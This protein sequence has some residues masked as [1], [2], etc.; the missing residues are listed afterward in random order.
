MK[1]LIVLAGIIFTFS[2][3]FPQDFGFAYRQD[4]F[5]DAGLDT[6]TA[7]FFAGFSGISENSEFAI[8]PFFF[9]TL[10]KENF[11][12]QLYVR[13]TSDSSLMRHYSGIPREIARFGLNSAEFDRAVVGFQNGWISTEFGRTREIWGYSHEKNLI[14]SG[15]SP[16]YERFV[17]QADFA[18][19]S[20]RYFFGFLESRQDVT[21]DYVQ[22]YL[23]GR[24]LEYHNANLIFGL[25][26]VSILY[27]PNRPIDFA[28]L[29]PLGFH[30]EIEQNNR[31]NATHGNR[32]NAIWFLDLDWFAMENLRFAGSVLMD[33]F[34]LDFADREQNRGDALGFLLHSAWTPKKSG[35]LVTFLAD[36]VRIGTYVFQHE[37]ENCNFVSHG[38]LLGHPLGNDAE[39][40]SG[41]LRFI[42]PQKIIVEANLGFRQ[43]GANSLLNQNPYTKYEEFVVTDFPSGT[44]EI[45][46][47]LRFKIDAKPMKYLHFG[48]ESELDLVELENSIFRTELDVIFR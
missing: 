6:A 44:V 46:K 11:Y 31:S 40:F 32:E 25:G 29:N 20:Y 16:A 33:E 10:K 36:W 5:D 8:S 27:G 2:Q 18:R 37:H 34:Q 48:F 26:E 22:R 14:L 19:F 39:E 21:Y 17:L 15:N 1:K 47:F 43:R 38:Q 30:L 35:I 28:F 3:P 4:V 13:A 24:R 41:G 23:A 12:A 9:G 45:S 42:F 7:D